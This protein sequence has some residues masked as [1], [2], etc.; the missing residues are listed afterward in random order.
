[1]RESHQ[2]KTTIRSF[3]DLKVW[4]EG[5]VL[6]LQVYKV[7]DIFPKKE[8]YSLTDQLRRSA[9]SITSNIAEGF[10]RKGIREK[11]QYYYMAKGSL[12]ELQNQLLI[13]RD[14]GYIADESFSMLATR[15]VAVH[16]LLNGFIT[17]TRSRGGLKNG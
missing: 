4:Q 16:K 7:T 13:A 1:M 9:I 3:T 5:H 14:I 17:S 2:Y 8:Q 15:T 6:V 10:S 12:A 11:L